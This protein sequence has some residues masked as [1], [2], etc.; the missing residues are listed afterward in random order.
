V[1]LAFAA[2]LPMGQLL[3]SVNPLLAVID[4][5]VMAAPDW[6]VSVAVCDALVLPTMVAPKLREPGVNISAPAV[7]LP[8]SVA[9]CGL[10]AALS[11]NEIVSLFEP[12]ETGL[13]I[14]ET[15][16]DAPAANDDEED[17]QLFAVIAKSDPMVMELIITAELS[18]FVSVSVFAP[19]LLPTAILPQLS[20]VGAS[21]SGA[22]IPVPA[23]FAVCGLL[24]ASLFTVRVPVCAPALCGVKL[25]EI[26]QLPLPARVLPH[27]FVSVKL[28]LDVVIPKI[29]MSV[30]PLLVSVKLTGVLL[31]PV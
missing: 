4:D 24:L 3:V 21:E 8:V 17:G 30:V 16:H 6:F 14:T 27:V 13:K 23:S 1:Q 20:A 26:V 25:T 28:L 5:R 29:A 19:E 31:F 2:K 9:V 10:L 15:V 18:V 7:A 22:A 11:L 12:L